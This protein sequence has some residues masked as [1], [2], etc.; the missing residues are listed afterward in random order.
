MPF[1]VTIKH[2]IDDQTLAF[3]NRLLIDLI[4]KLRFVENIAQVGFSV[5]NRPPQTVQKPFKPAGYLECSALLLFQLIILNF[6][7]SLNL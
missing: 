3:I 4:P 2:T 6:P 7:L 1:E 5:G